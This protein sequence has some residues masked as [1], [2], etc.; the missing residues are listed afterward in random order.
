MFAC[1][2]LVFHSYLISQPA[3]INQ[4]FL[5]RAILSL[6]HNKNEKSVSEQ[7]AVGPSFFMIKVFYCFTDKVDRKKRVCPYFSPSQ[8]V[9]DSQAAHQNTHKENSDVSPIQKPKHPVNSAASVRPSLKALGSHAD[10]EETFPVLG[11]LLGATH[12]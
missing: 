2:R 3:A 6:R 8:P 10:P 4:H 1:A 7:Q 9:A 5:T 11:Y 12:L